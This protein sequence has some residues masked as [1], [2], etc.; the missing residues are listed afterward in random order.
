MLSPI[1]PDM[2]YEL[3]TVSEPSL[4]P[5]GAR[6]AFVR[7]EV[8]KEA[9]ESRSQIMMMSPP[10]GEA[11][12]FTGGDRDAGPRFAPDGQTLA[13]LRS[14][15]AGTRQVWL[16]PVSGGEAQQLTKSPGGVHGFAWSPGR[17]ST[18]IRV[19]CGPPPAP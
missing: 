4:S 6:L 3:I 15:D 14:D 18:G 11:V 5:D 2:I 1:T 16:I 19:G 13:F 9:M 12:P 17:P 7:S 8:D 10:G